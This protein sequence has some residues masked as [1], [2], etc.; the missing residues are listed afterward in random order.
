[1]KLSQQSS[2]EPVIFRFEAERLIR[3]LNLKTRPMALGERL[4]I[5]PTSLQKQQSNFASTSESNTQHCNFAPYL[6]FCI[7]FSPF[8]VL[9]LFNPDHP[10]HITTTP[11]ATHTAHRRGMSP[12]PPPYDGGPTLAS[13]HKRRCASRPITYRL[14]QDRVRACMACLSLYLLP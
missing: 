4:F 11:T 5:L 14:G 1:M 10:S 12:S 13:R 9:S 2:F 6:R 8:R 3:R 7:R